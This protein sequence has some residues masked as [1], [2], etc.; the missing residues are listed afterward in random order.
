MTDF[1]LRPL[2]YIAGPYSHPDPVVNTRNAVLLG[3]ELHATG[4]VT[5][6]V[7]HLTH[8]WHLI[9]PH[10]VDHWY[11]YDFAVLRRCDALIR[12][13]GASKGADDEVAYAIGQSIPVFHSVPT[14]L[15]WASGNA[16]GGGF[17]KGGPKSGW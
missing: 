8:L 15:S 16:E 17:D 10:D 12:M 5:C 2:I 9:A 7:P 4:I 6:H 1:H 14:L 3:E 13:K 11:G